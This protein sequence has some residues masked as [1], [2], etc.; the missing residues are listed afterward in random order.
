MFTKSN[1]SLIHSSITI[2]RQLRIH[3][4]IHLTTLHR[5]GQTPAME[6]RY[7]IVDAR[8]A[9]A[10]SRVIAVRLGSRHHREGAL[11]LRVLVEYLYVKRL[12]KNSLGANT[13][14]AF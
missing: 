8:A 11:L 12:L 14:L 7:R 13:F 5:L 3:T 4:R 9:G 6:V 10:L 2:P 1:S